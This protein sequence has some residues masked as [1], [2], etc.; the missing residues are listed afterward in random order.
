MKLSKE[1]MRDIFEAIAY[2]Q[3]GIAAKHGLDSS[4]ENIY[5]TGLLI[6]AIGISYCSQ[7]S[8]PKEQMLTELSDMLDGHGMVKELQ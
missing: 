1:Y 8:K 6:A 7:C 2:T 3:P 5:K 4:E